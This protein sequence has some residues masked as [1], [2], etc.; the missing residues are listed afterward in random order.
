MRINA[1]GCLI[2]AVV[3]IIVGIV[4]SIIIGFAIW[5]GRVWRGTLTAEAPAIVTNVVL[6]EQRRR[7]GG[8]SYQTIVDYSY[9]ISGRT[10]SGQRTESGNNT[11]EYRSGARRKVCYNP[12]DHSDSLLVAL[13]YRCGQ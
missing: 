2:T 3:L 11:N 10:Y 7:R 13:D 12:A 1:K 9:T 6:R 5:R 4:V 8:T